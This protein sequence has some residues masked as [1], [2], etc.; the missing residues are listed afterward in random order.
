MD[1]F[2]PENRVSTRENTVK[3]NV[4]G[5]HFEVLYEPTLTLHRDSLLHQLAENAADG[6]EIFVEADSDLFQ[7]MLNYH[8]HRKIYIPFTVSK[9][10]VLREAQILG[11]PVRDEDIIQQTPPLGDVMCLADSVFRESTEDVERQLLKAKIDTLAALI[12]KCALQK[13]KGCSGVTVTSQDVMAMH[14]SKERRCASWGIVRCPES[15]QVEV[16]TFEA[17][18]R[19]LRIGMQADMLSAALEQWGRRNGYI[20]QVSD[21]D[22]TGTWCKF[23]NFSAS[24]SLS[25][26]LAPATGVSAGA[27]DGKR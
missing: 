15:S 23:M 6:E 16:N 20:V 17:T 27:A 2:R 7:Y 13:M 8:R 9:D 11:L 12:I 24:F 10:A 3:F 19:F 4:G 5:K 14:G 1:N 18:M 26:N 25:S 22:E 21:L